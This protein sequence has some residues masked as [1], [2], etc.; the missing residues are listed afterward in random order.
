MYAWKIVWSVGDGDV[1]CEFDDESGQLQRKIARRED[2][3]AFCCCCCP[4]ESKQAASS[5]TRIA[6]GKIH[7]R[8][9]AARSICTVQNSIGYRRPAAVLT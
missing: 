9:I 5:S 8:F 1:E 6:K 3:V 4:R 7:G 2:P